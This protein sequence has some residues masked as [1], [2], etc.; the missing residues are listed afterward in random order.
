MIRHKHASDLERNLPRWRT[1][2]GVWRKMILKAKIVCE[3]M[4]RLGRRYTSDLEI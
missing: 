2:S 4:S 1:I 3:Y